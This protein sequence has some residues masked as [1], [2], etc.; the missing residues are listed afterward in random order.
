MQ[1]RL[2]ARE[3]GIAPGDSG[4][5]A[6]IDGRLASVN[7]YG[8]TFGNDFGDVDLI[9]NSSWGEYSGYVPIY[10][11]AD[12]I[13]G[14]QASVPEPESWALMILGF[15]FVGGALRRRA[16]APLAA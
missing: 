3:V 16:P 7:S 1:A 8:L 2:G 10:L 9:L 12:W 11:H 4:G 14:I 15:G 5:P 6:F 13:R